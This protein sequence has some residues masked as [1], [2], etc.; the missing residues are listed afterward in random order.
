MKTVIEARDVS[1]NYGEVKAV[2]HVNLPVEEGELFGLLGPNGSGK[3][4]MIRMLTGQT[5]PTAGSASVL[6]LDVVKDP[7]GVRERVGIIPEQESPPSFLTAA[8]YLYF[9]GAVRKISGIDERRLGGSIFLTSPIKR[10]CSARTSHAAPARNLCS[11]RHSSTSPRSRS[12]TSRSSTST[13]SCRR[14]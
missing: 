3:T 7:I 10:T 8:E 5:R 2:D 13:R 1:K 9:V 11:P 14:R 4:T 12:S 6:G